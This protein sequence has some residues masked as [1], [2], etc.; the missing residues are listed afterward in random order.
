MI[1]D[2]E[3]EVRMEVRDKLKMLELQIVEKEEIIREK[4][5]ILN[6]LEVCGS[7]AEKDGM[8]GHQE[9]QH[10][11][12]EGERTEIQSDHPKLLRLKS[13]Q[14]QAREELR[15]LEFLQTQESHEE[16]HHL[17]DKIKHLE[18]LLE[19]MADSNQEVIG[20]IIHHQYPF[21]VMSGKIQKYTAV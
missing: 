17:R 21:L 10:L 19:D 16:N 5:N 2:V 13:V 18:A 4:E 11:E 7:P 8:V 20:K 6:K 14:E 3:E 12:G 15:R 1:A 9:E